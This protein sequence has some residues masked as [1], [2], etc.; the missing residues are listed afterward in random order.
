[1]KKI[2]PIYFYIAFFILNTLN[3]YLLIFA[4]M[5]PNISNYAFQWSSFLY[6]LMGNIGVLLVLHAINL[7]FNTKTKSRIRF[8]LITTFVTSFLCLALAVYANIFSLFFKFSHLR[9]FQNPNQGAFFEFYTIYAINILSHITHSIHMFPFVLLLILRIFTDTS[10]Q[11]MYSYAFRMALYFLGL[12]LIITPMVRI[13]KITKNTIY[14]ANINGLYGCYET[15]VY[16]YYFH[17]LFYYLSPPPSTNHN[18][19]IADFLAYHSQDTYVN[20]IDNQTYTHT[21]PFT[22]LATGQNLFIIQLE[23]V[24]NLVIDLEVDGIEITP[25]L[26]RLANSGL[27]YDQFYSTA[28]IGNTGDAEFSAITGLYGN[29]NDLT[30]YHYTGSQYPS[31]AKDFIEK[32]YTVFSTHGNVGEFYLRSTEHINTLGFQTHYDLEYFQ[33]QNPNAPLIHGYLD[34]M[35]FFEACVD[36]AKQ[37]SPFFAYAIAVTSHSPYVPT[38]EIKAHHFTG[39]TPLASSYLDFCHYTDSAIGH[40]I[41]IMEQTGLL[42]NTVIV[43]F[44]DHTSSLFKH[45]VESIY[46]QDIDDLTFRLSMQNVPLIIHHPT[47]FANQTISNPF[48][49]SDIYR[50]MANLFGLNSTYRFGFDLLTDEPSYVYSPRNLDLIFNDFIITVPNKKVYGSI[51]QPIDYYIEI[52]NRHKYANDGILKTRYFE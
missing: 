48:G 13:D 15:G 11:R 21:N 29:G 17:D 23:A 36:I 20:P 34:D 24:N 50:T 42:D 31:L 38:P 37:T 33:T 32:D 41:D 1:M 49:I 51:S 26:N 46:K 16:A 9:S 2:P 19:A 52:F 18:Q 40:F 28:G 47:L 12:V 25:N 27:Y 22:G 6:S 35:Y 7:T 45:D 5:H 3:T 10:K 44:G 4:L 43:I 30:V 14:E 39:L 8:L